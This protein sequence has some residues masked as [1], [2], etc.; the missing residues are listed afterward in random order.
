[1]SSTA[2][3]LPQLALVGVGGAAGA[4]LRWTI[5]EAWTATDLP[6]PTLV[7]NVVGCGLL[8][9]FTSD[10][11]DQNANRLLAA[12]FCGGLTTFSTLSVEVVQ[13]LDT[14]RPATAIAYIAASVALGL[15]AFTSVRSVRPL[16]AREVGEW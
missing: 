13:L 2:E 4:L 6:W 1:M 5:A 15:V 11:F 8:A 7:V 3:R 16:P 10:G 14:N 9:L 12:G